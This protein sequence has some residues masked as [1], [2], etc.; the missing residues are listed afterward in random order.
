MRFPQG[1]PEESRCVSLLGFS[2]REVWKKLFLGFTLGRE[3][4]I[5]FRPLALPHLSDNI[6]SPVPGLAG[7]RRERQVSLCTG[8]LAAPEPLEA[9]AKMPVCLG[10]TSIPS[11]VGAASP[12]IPC[13]GILGDF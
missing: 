7:G 11:T 3:P 8:A 10:C 4:E 13:M 6:T 5:T 9:G 1:Q 12:L 2:S